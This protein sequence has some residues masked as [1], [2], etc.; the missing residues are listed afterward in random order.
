MTLDNLNRKILFLLR[1]ISLLS[2]FC[3][4]WILARVAQKK[5]RILF[6]PQ[7]WNIG[8]TAKFTKN[9][10]NYQKSSNYKVTVVIPQKDIESFRKTFASNLYEDVLALSS[11]F[12]IHNTH[13][14]SVKH[15]L[16]KYFLY[17]VI[18][19]TNIVLNLKVKTRAKIVLVSVAH[20]SELM[21]IFMLPGNVLY[22]L[23]T[24]PWMKIDEGNSFILKHFIGRNK[25]IVT[26]SSFARDEIISKWGIKDN[27]DFVEV[28]PNYADD[29]GISK[30]RKNNDR[31]IITCT[32]S[33]IKDKN[34]D[35]FID[36]AQKI[37]ED[38]KNVLFIWAGTGI[39][40]D[41]C[42]ERVRNTKQIKFLGH[43]KDVSKLLQVSDI[44]FHTSVRE[45][46][47]ISVLEAMS[48][49]LPCVVS[50][51]GGVG[52]MI[53][54]GYN[55]YIFGQSDK[56]LAV[57]KLKRLIKNKYKII[58]MGEDSRKLFLTRFTK[59]IWT[60]KI[61]EIFYKL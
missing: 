37:I 44:Y 8:G 23:H 10:L 11:A 49:G 46:Q 53:K 40:L 41:H 52:D 56:V 3:F 59:N 21:Q 26:V 34:P 28:I 14:Y 6:I 48:S 17:E 43:L 35:F 5:E 31:I 32:S 38:N 12:W 50:D 55:G 29:I 16:F 57:E 13:W 61:Y 22:F 30:T 58:R 20:P 45:S 47:C 4:Y 42:R 18:S 2:T 1:F 33:A 60:K 39:L 15:S 9:I 24:V 27:R 36:V 25:K 54:D 19:Q 51:S 7:N